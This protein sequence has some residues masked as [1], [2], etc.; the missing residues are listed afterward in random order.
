MKSEKEI[1]EIYEFIGYF[2]DGCFMNQ[3]Y[4]KGIMDA[5]SFV[6]YSGEHLERFQD[7]FKKRYGGEKRHSS[8][9]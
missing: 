5:L 4:R 7:Y 1:V 9:R 2:N 8:H 6:L 3:D